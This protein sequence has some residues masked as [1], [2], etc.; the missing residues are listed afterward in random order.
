[1]KGERNF[2]EQGTHSHSVSTTQHYVRES[3]LT[4]IP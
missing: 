4:A 3:S 2:D 1:M